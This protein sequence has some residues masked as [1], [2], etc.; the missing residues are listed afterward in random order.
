MKNYLRFLFPLVL[1]LGSARADTDQTILLARSFLGEESALD[2]V[3]AV[4]YKGVLVSST[5]NAE[6]EPQQT[7][8]AIEITFVE[9]FYQRIRITSAARIETTALDDYEA[10]QRIENPEDASQWR[11]T[12]LDTA[13]IRRLRANT[14]ENLAFFKGLDAAGGKVEDL[15]RVD[16]EG[17]TLHK[18]AYDHGYGI[19]F[20]RYIDPVTGRLVMSE[21]DTGARIVESGVNIINGV[22]FPNEVVTTSTR[23]DGAVQRVQVEFESIEVNP[24][25]DLQMFRVP[26]ITKQ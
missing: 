7:T 4:R 16:V 3:T 14:W 6:G 1:L 22:R 9:P 12:L 17:K 8:A 25:V 13:Q 10:W 26:S 24:D 21:T 2:A 11:L 18:L 5:T 19:I 20:Y 23:A 15:G